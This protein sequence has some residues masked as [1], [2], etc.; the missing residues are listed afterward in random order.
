MIRIFLFFFCLFES[1]HLNG[2][3]SSPT[4]SPSHPPTV[5]PTSSPTHSPQ[6]M[7]W[8][9]SIVS[10][11]SAG[12][13]SDNLR[14]YVTS[15]REI[16]RKKGGHFRIVFN[17]SSP[18]LGMM[19]GTSACIEIG[20][21]VPPIMS[22]LKKTDAYFQVS[23]RT[24]RLGEFIDVIVRRIGDG[25]IESRFDTT[26]EL[27]FSSKSLHSIAV[28]VSVDGCIPIE[29]VALWDDHTNWQGGVVP[30]PTDSVIF[31]K[32][33]GYIRLSKDTTVSSLH[34]LGGKI[35][36]HNSPCPD[37]WSLS[38]PLNALG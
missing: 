25:K 24:R 36:A 31:P 34:M 27:Y 33:S 15:N 29:T 5:S 7:N 32:D 13:G 20:S 35:I 26:Y 19:N 30:L 14:V 10:F 6:T 12:D 2:V 21:A 16:Y 38:S 8:N 17:A 9:S 3:L 22:L 1:F 18:Q 11:L 4:I 37:G 23:N 28:S